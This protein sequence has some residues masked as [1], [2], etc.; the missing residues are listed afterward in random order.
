[1]KKL[2]LE[3]KISTW[4]ISL[5]L[6]FIIFS[7]VSTFYILK[8]QN[9]KE[10]LESN[11]AKTNEINDFLNK[12]TIFSQKY[13]NFS[14]EFNPKI[15]G[16]KVTYSKPFNPGEEGYLYLLTYT[17]SNLENKILLNTVTTIDSDEKESDDKLLNDLQKL[18]LEANNLKKSKVIWLN[19]S[20]DETK[21]KYSVIKL[22]REIDKSKFLLYILSYIK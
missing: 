10:Q 20:S 13:N 5:F 22:E 3:D 7:N 6:I 14:L 18:K 8:T 21:R 2:K 1:M 19:L 16:K 12:V 9:D 11:I 15:E 4:Y 17:N